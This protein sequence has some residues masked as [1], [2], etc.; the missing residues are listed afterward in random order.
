[1]KRYRDYN[2]VFI[3]PFFY[4]NKN[5]ILHKIPV[6]KGEKRAGKIDN[7]YSHEKL[8]DDYYNYGDY[9]DFPRGSV[10]WDMNKDRGII[11]IDPCIEKETD[12]IERIVK[13]FK[14]TDYVIE[15]DEHYVCPD[16]AGDIWGK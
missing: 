14:L 10:V 12:T 8:Y 3:G 9:I 11:Y 15:H 4:I 1:M 16:C 6:S 5:F 7:P 13:L 2:K